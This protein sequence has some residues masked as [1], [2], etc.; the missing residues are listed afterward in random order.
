MVAYNYA[1]SIRQV[2]TV[3]VAIGTYISKWMDV[4]IERT[5]INSIGG[6]RMIDPTC[7]GYFITLSES[8]PNPPATQHTF[9]RGTGG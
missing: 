1:Q 4:F 7:K 3:T 2:L 6:K 9:P 5:Q 8:R